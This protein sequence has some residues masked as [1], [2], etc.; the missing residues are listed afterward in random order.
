M[1][2]EAL[3]LIDDVVYFHVWC[4]S[5]ARNCSLHFYYEDGDFRLL[6]RADGL[7]G[8]G[9]VVLLMAPTVRRKQFPSFI[10]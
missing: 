7:Q 1:L 4:Q 6:R 3:A 9:T 10:P 8:C 2:S 5:L